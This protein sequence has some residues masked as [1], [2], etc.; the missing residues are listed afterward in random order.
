MF[1]FGETKMRL[2]ANMM[3]KILVIISIMFWGRFL[4]SYFDVET[5]EEGLRLD[6]DSLRLNVF[7]MIIRMI[8]I[9]TFLFLRNFLYLSIF[10]L[11]LLLIHCHQRTEILY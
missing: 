9:C 2:L 6:W 7:T 3:G 4:K 1:A 10:I 5:E 8:I 11:F